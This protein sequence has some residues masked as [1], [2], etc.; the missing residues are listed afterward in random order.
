LVPILYLALLH[1][2]AVA[3]AGLMALC[4]LAAAVVVAQVLQQQTTQ[5]L[6]ALSA[7]E[8][9]AATAL[10]MRTQMW[11]AAAAVERGR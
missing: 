4:L 6:L 10:P 1:L 9:L 8:I 11:A 3:A 5:V 2:P 7:K